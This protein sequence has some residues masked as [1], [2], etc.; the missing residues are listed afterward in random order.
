MSSVGLAGHDGDLCLECDY[1]EDKVS[2]SRMVTLDTGYLAT[3]GF[4]GLRLP[5]NISVFVGVITIM[6]AGHDWDLCHY[7]MRRTRLV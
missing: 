2:G 5:S 6:S 1:E 3:V 7:A 4:H